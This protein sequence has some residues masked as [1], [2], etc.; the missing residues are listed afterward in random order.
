MIKILHETRSGNIKSSTTEPPLHVPA[1]RRRSSDHH[2]RQDPPSAR[3]RDSAP[4]PRAASPVPPDQQHNHRQPSPNRHVKIWKKN[5]LK[6]NRHRR[7][8][9]PEPNGTE[10]KEATDRSSLHSRG[11]TWSGDRTK[12]FRRRPGG[13][14]ATQSPPMSS[15]ESDSAT[16]AIVGARSGGFGRR[17]WRRRRGWRWRGGN[18]RKRREE[19]EMAR[20]IWSESELESLFC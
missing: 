3:T 8:R 9:S 16:D 6:K 4:S 11:R 2:R 14:E 20:L 13:A 7:S 12:R 19:K 5:K 17:R 18:E 15:L 1:R 10:P